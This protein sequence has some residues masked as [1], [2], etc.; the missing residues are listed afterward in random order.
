MLLTL[1]L[2]DMKRQ[3]FHWM[4]YNM[5][6]LVILVA[7]RVF[8]KIDL[9]IA[10]FVIA[11]SFQAYLMSESHIR[12]K[13]MIE[14]FL[15]GPI[16]IYQLLIARTFYFIIIFMLMYLLMACIVFFLNQVFHLKHLV[17][18]MIFSSLG[19]TLDKKIFIII[20]LPF[21][22]LAPMFP[23]LIS[24][25]TVGTVLLTLSVNLWTFKN[26]DKEKF[27]ETTLYKS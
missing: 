13:R 9:T 16:C 14:P 26:I 3:R 21:I 5:F 23:H 10:P 12:D 19:T 24:Y 7:L 22:V 11:I 8:T 2:Y 4:Y 1:L 6:G 25:I 18:G 27:L 15:S 17:M 20:I